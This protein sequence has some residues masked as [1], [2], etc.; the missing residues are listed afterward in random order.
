MMQNLADLARAAA[1]DVTVVDVHGHL[2]RSH[3][4]GVRSTSAGLLESMDTFGIAA[5]MI[6]PQ[7]TDPGALAIHDEIAELVRQRPGRAFG[8]ALLDPRMPARD[9]EAHAERLLEGA[10]FTAL[11]LHTFGHGVAP[12]DEISDKVFRAA[13]RHNRPVM[14]HTGLGG[15]HTLPDRVRAPLKA[16][17]DVPVV[18]CHAG[19]AA[20]WSQ[21]LS[22]AED[23]ENVMLEPSWSPGFAVGLMVE[24][25][26]AGR[27]L[28]G[29]DHASNLPVELIK[30]AALQLSHAERAAVLGG[31]AVQLFR[32]RPLFK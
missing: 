12:D 10:Q 14:I 4:T 31:N 11:K 13:Q 30:F 24:R 20:F 15:P 32:L 5:T 23:F 19:F 22:V 25:L 3:S 28:F 26:G 27:V 8:I 2:G 16:Y 18:L 21:A 9:Y 17:P 1:G 29:S 6:M 7:P